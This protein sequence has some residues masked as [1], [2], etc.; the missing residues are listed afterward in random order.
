MKKLL[1]IL[2][3]GGA[4]YVGTVL[5][6]ELIND[7][8]SIKCLDRFF[9]GD[10]YLAQNQFKNKL[11]LIKD[12]IRWFKPEI[13]NDVDVVIDL[14]ALSN[15]PVGELEPKKTYEINYLGRVR[16]AKL[17]KDFG[18]KQYI[19]ASTASVYGQQTKIVDETFEVNPITA[20]AKATIRA[21]IDILPLNEDKFSVTSLR[22][23][24]IYGLSP[25]MRFDV[26]VNSMILKLF[27]TKKITIGGRTNKR[28]FIH[29]KDATRA[30][31]LMI[32]S[33][34]DKIA[35]E[36]FNVGSDQQ[37]YE[38]ETL[39]KEIGNSIGEKYEF[40]FDDTPDHRSYFASFKKIHEL[41]F[42]TKFNV[43]DGTR[44]IYQALKKGTVFDSEKTITVKW[45]KHL[46]ESVSAQK[47]YG[48]NG[49]IL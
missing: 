20:Y 44:E 36:I 40:E 42:N 7:G 3:T 28:P 31:Q 23:S 21:E 35:G 8:H 19:L 2:V 27:K 15:D 29:I 16:V 45:Y 38:M 17:S 41:G 10:E 30:Y 1:K 39:G 34:K 32:N 26:A 11:E 46:L 37:N 25:R 5:I 24:S 14:A 12:D 49:K 33:S 47:K 4:G 18:V 48:L 43:R 6:P 22:F 13:L 9:F